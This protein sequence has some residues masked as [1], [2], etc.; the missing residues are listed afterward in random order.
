MNEREQYLKDVKRIVVKVGTSTLTHPTGLLDLKRIEHLVRQLADIQNK[1]IQVVLVSSGAIAA[2]M[3][4]LGLKVKPKTIPGK[5]AAAA[6][7]QGT[8]IHMYQKIFSEYGKTVAQILLTEKDCIDEKRYLNVYNTFKVL[9]SRGVIPIVNENDAVA[10]DER[11]VVDN[12]T[13][14]AMVTELI[15][16][17]LLIILSDIDGLYDSNPRTDPNANIIYNVKEITDEI[18]DSA[19]GAGSDLGTGGMATKITAAK[20]VVDANSNMIIAE[21]SEPNIIT[22]IL[23][24]KEIGTLFEGKPKTT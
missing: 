11:N 18:I 17:D 10:T 20:I 15:D 12:D 6:V 4:E 21:G 9:L 22:D 14:A 24:G 1:G 16:A 13:L 2:G 19:D 7:G 8:L 5:Q 23:E 3:G